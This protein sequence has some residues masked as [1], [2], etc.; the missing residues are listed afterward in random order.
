MDLAHRSRNNDSHA[1]HGDLLPVGARQYLTLEAEAVTI[2]IFATQAIPLL[3]ATPAYAAAACRATRPH[4]TPGQVRDLGALNT[5]RQE[6][7]DRT[8]LTL[9][10]VLD[11]AALHRPVASPHSQAGQLAHLAERA[12]RARTTVQVLPLP[13]AWPV[14]TTPF[15]LLAFTD[16]VAPAGCAVIATGQHLITRRDTDI[17]AVDNAFNSLSQAA[18]SAEDSVRLIADLAAQAVGKN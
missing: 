15:S 10:V 11:E 17:Q 7:A 16:S 13:T 8:G 12:T 5:R 6:L 9:R 18:L 1:P 3:L 14:L 2:S 4:L